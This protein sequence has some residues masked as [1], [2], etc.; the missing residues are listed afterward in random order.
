[1]LTHLLPKDLFTNYSQTINIMMSLLVNT[2]NYVHANLFFSMH[3]LFV[4]N[5]NFETFGICL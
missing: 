2:G 1:M 5:V 4:L 3:K